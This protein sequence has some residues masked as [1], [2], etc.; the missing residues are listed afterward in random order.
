MRHAARVI[1]TML[2]KNVVFQQRMRGHEHAQIPSSSSTAVVITPGGQ[3]DGSLVPGDRPSSSSHPTGTGSTE[4]ELVPVG[5]TMPVRGRGRSLFDAGLE[6]LG[7]A[8]LGLSGLDQF[9]VLDAE[10]KT[11]VADFRAAR[12]ETASADRAAVEVPDAVLALQRQV[13]TLQ[14]QI[15]TMQGQLNEMLLLLRQKAA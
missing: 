1:I 2:R 15:T 7:L 13:G 8:G 3:P 6:K 9:K 10:F 12:A 5:E 4:V 14:T 11:A